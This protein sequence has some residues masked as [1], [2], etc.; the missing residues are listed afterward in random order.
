MF[1]ALQTDV[2]RVVRATSDQKAL[3][4]KPPNPKP[5]T[6]N[7]RLNPRVWGFGP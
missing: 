1:A 3:P 6:V 2:S 7:I 4:P 5:E